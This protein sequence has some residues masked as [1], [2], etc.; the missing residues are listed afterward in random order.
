MLRTECG[1]TW[2]EKRQGVGAVIAPVAI[3]GGAYMSDW[4][5][6]WVYE[7]ASY[8]HIRFAPNTDYD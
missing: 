7:S 8:P 3:A 4:V 5:S 2:H 1:G 6:D